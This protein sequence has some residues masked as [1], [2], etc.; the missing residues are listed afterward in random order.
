MPTDDERTWSFDG[1][2]ARYDAAVAGDAQHYYS[3]YAEVL[4]AVV[5][6]AGAAPGVRVLDIG[7][8]TGALA[9]R[10][11][12]RGA[13]VVGLDPSAAM[14]AQ[15]RAKA[16]ADPRIQLRQVDQP[17]LR[18]LYPDSSFDAVV[19]TYAYHHIPHTLRAASVGEMLR[20]LAPGGRW[21]VG[22][23]AFDSAE[24]EARA[25]REFPWLEEEYFTR[26][27]EL[28]AIFAERGLEL[29]ARQLTP[30]TWL[31]WVVLG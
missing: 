7:T 14:L 1:W 8:G 25:L 9:L 13:D 31:L 3:C 6:L 19:S 17:F 2:A 21:V 16:G 4:D 30:V 23:L 15:A 26:I 28:R 24:V 20:V 18:L 12:A 5:G 10:C 22:D 27:D 11:L 29:H